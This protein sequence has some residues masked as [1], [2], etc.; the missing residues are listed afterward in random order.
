MGMLVSKGIWISPSDQSTSVKST[1]ASGT[2]ASATTSSA[3]VLLHWTS[4][5]FVSESR[6]MRPA[7]GKKRAITRFPEPRAERDE[8][9]DAC[10]PSPSDSNRC[11]RIGHADECAP[12]AHCI[13]AAPNLVPVEA[14]EMAIAAPV[15][16][17]EMAQRRYSVHRLGNGEERKLT[18]SGEYFMRGSTFS[19]Q[20]CEAQLDTS[21]SPAAR[22]AQTGQ[23]GPHISLATIASA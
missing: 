4:G 15:E 11:P 8:L 18:H 17:A 22:R 12:D 21:P 2:L 1:S 9:L 10:L 7:K 6:T 16:A 5:I 23:L 20:E 19:F 14:V 13:R 3:P